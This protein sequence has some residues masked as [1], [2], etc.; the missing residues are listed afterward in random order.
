MSRVRPIRGFAL[1]VDDQPEHV[2]DGVVVRLGSASWR[3]NL[4]YTVA[5]VADGERFGSGDR[6]VLNDANAGRSVFIDGVAYRVVRTSDI[7]GV[8]E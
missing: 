4:D 3:K 5:S 7:T 2:E 6:V 8:V 1:L